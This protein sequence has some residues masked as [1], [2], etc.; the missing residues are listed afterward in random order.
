M[1]TCYVVSLLAAVVACVQ[2]PPSHSTEIGV[3]WSPGSAWTHYECD[4]F[5]T[6]GDVERLGYNSGAAGSI[7]FAP[8]DGE[9]Q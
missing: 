6:G 2:A 5:E 9:H 8:V 1:L 7:Q 3:Y 4:T